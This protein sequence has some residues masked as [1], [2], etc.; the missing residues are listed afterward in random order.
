VKTVVCIIADGGSVN[1]SKRTGFKSRNSLPGCFEDTL[2]HVA[3]DSPLDRDPS[4][5]RNEREIREMIKYP[6]ADC[7]SLIA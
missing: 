2:L 7:Q 6:Q 3:R 4:K 1:L 5:R